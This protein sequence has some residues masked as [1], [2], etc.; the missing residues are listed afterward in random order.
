MYVR[1]STVQNDCITVLTSI[2]LTT[3]GRMLPQFTET[4]RTSDSSRQMNVRRVPG[5][6]CTKRLYH[7]TSMQHEEYKVQSRKCLAIFIFVAR[8]AFH[9]RPLI[10]PPIKSRSHQTTRPVPCSPIYDLSSRTKPYK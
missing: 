5:F 1:R 8:C 10:I 6:H 4:P 9:A 3:A 2:Q 7:G